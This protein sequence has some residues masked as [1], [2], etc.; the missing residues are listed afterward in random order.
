MPTDLHQFDNSKYINLETY[1]KSGKSVTTPVWFVKENE[2]FFV[3]TRSGTGKV[4]R[5]RNDSNVKIVPCDF[6]GTPKGEWVNGIARFMDSTASPRI[7]NLRNKKYGFQARLASLFT[8]GKG[9]YIVISIQI[10]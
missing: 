9:K 10:I 2:E 4:K 3:V 7:I 5:L 1:K 6:R 8:M